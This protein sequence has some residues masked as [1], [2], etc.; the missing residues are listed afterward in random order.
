MESLLSANYGCEHTLGAVGMHG[1]DGMR[2]TGSLVYI[3]H[4]LQNYRGP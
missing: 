1:Y 3:S 4:N 2:T